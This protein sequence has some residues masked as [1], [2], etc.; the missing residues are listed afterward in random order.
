MSTFRSADAKVSA[1]CHEL[2]TLINFLETV[3]RTLEE[4]QDRP[5][6]LASMD[7]NLWRQSVLSLEDCKT[8]IAEL[9]AFIERI[10]TVAKSTGIFRRAKIA[11]DLTM[12]SRDI[13]AFQEKINKSNW[14]LQ[15]MLSAINV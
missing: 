4:C 15:T 8:T 7:E 1:L 11:V 5:L 3:K 6:S 9:E 12:Y 10:K 13:S 2:G 14:A